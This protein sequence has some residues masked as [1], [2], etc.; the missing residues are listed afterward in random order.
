MHVFVN[1]VLVRN[2]S[3]DEIVNAT[4]VMAVEAYNASVNTPAEFQVL[5]DRGCGS[6]AVWTR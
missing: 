6:V 1:G 3:L 2:A 4:E 5:D